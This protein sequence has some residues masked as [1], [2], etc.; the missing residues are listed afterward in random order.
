[1]DHKERKWV[2]VDLFSLA[3]DRAINFLKK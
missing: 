3:Q 1:M 2:V